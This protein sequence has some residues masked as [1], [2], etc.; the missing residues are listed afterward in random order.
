METLQDR[1]ADLDAAESIADLLVGNIRDI[2]YL[3]AQCKILDLADNHGIV[4]C[5]NHPK[6][7]MASQKRVDW[8]KVA[9]IKIVLIGKNDEQ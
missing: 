2:D 4:F 6:R 9:R 7:H 5:S 8:I 3:D 1:L